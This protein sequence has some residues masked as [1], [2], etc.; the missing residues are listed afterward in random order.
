MT[1]A[2]AISSDG[3]MLATGSGDGVVRLWELA[4]G[5]MRATFNGHRGQVSAVKF[6]GDGKILIS[7]CA[8]ATALC[9]DLTGHGPG[10]RPA[11]KALSKEDLQTQWENLH[12]RD[13]ELAYQALKVLADHPEQALVRLQMELK[14]VASIDQKAIAKWI[15]D[16][17][18]GEF[19]VR[20]KAVTELK[21]AGDVAWPALGHR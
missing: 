9:W 6:A 18:A 13:T 2:A 15:A 8:D 11:V 17:D 3:K 5:K 21:K 1:F 19:A 20:E 10:K 4:T 14:P 16:L 12:G 7:G